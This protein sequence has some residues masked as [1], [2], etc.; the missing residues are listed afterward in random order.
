MKRSREG[1]PVAVVTGAGRGIGKATA[2]AM[3]RAGWRVALVSRNKGELESVGEAIGGRGGEATCHVGDVSDLGAVR[4]TWARICEKW[5][6]PDCLVN[7]AAVMEPV[8][9][10]FEARSTGVGAI[11]GDQPDRRVL[12]HPYRPEGHGRATA[13]ES[14]EHRFRHGHTGLPAFQRLLGIQGGPDSPDPCPGRRG[15][16]LRCDRERP[17]PGT[18]RHRHADGFEESL[19]QGGRRRDAGKIDWISRRKGC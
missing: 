3:A 10:S 17:G 19:R 2:I 5:G 7:N 9:A 16:S 11:D 8:G 4:E 12:L 13:R 1:P 18:G 15:S 14:V 6:T